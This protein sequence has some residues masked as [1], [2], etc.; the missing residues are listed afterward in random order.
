M[1]HGIRAAE[2]VLP[3]EDLEETRA[4]LVEHL[5]F[6]LVSISPAD[7]PRTA[8]LEGHGLRVRLDRDHDGDPGTLRLACVRPD[9]LARGRVALTAPNGTRVELV[10][11]EPALRLPPGEPG[12]SVCRASD[13]P[14]T[15]GR[16][17]MR[18]R[19]L[20]PGG[21]GG[22]FGA[23]HI[24]IRGGGTVP[25]Y[26]HAHRIRFQVICC[27]KGRVEVVYEDQGP[28]FVL[29]AGDV[30]LQ[31][32]RIR[33]RVLSS[34]A[35]LGVVEVS[36]PAEHETIV[37]HELALPST[38][39]RPD[40]RF[41]GQRFLHHRAAAGEWL[42]AARP[43]FDLRATGVGEASDGLVDV[44]FLRRAGSAEPGPEV[45]HGEL[46][47]RFVRSGSLTLVCEGEA[48]RSLSAGDA[49]AVPRELVHTLADASEDLELLEVASPGAARPRSAADERG[50]TIEP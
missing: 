45:H 14:W 27:V 2:V 37:D 40:R 49:F 24:E 34:S 4:F 46:L 31:P 28:P 12:L 19:D 18:Y 15:T 1:S 42:R 36:C 26:V 41:D 43:G 38:R 20:L 25:D 48:P 33:H 8:V 44:R 10:E 29:A 9:E 11:A 21:P 32:P 50:G 16:A 7:D 35:G 5:A 17:G 22:R 23:S 6:R 47:L 3:C 30:V 13:A 39:V